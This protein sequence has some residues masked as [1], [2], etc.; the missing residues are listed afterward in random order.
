MT[1]SLDLFVQELL[2]NVLKRQSEE[3]FL[4]YPLECDS[5]IT[6]EMILLMHT[7]DWYDR[8]LEKRLVEYLKRTLVDDGWVQY[9]GGPYDLSASIKAYFALKCAGESFEEPYMRAVAKKIRAHGGL[10]KANVFTRCTLAQFGQLSFKEVPWMP[11]ELILHPK[12][13]PFNVH[14][15]S[16]WARV[17]IVPLT[18]V[19][20]R[21]FKAKN[22]KNISVQELFVDLKVEKPKGKKR[23]F[24]L[25]DE[26]SRFVSACTP[27][28]IHAFA[29]K[30][31]LEWI[32]ERHNNI[33]GLG[34]IYTAMEYEI[35]ALL[36]VGHPIDDPSIQQA[37][38][39]IRFLEH[40]EARYSYMQPCVSPVWDTA[41]AMHALR[42]HQD[43][44]P[45][46]SISKGLDW[47]VSKQL[48]HVPGDWS[49]DRPKLE[50]G[51]WAFQFNNPFYPDLD[52]TAMCGWAMATMDPK[53]YSNSIEKAKNWLLG[54]QSKNGGFAAF[55]ID[56]TFYYLNSIPFAD[57]G[58]LLDPPTEDV[59]GR[60]LSFFGALN[61]PALNPAVKKAV[62]YLK[63]SQQPDGSWWGRWGT[64][65]LYG[66][67]SVITGLMQIGAS[68]HEPWIQR[69]IEFL[70]SRQNP[71]GGWGESCNSYIEGREKEKAPSSLFHTAIVLIALFY[72]KQGEREEVK[73]GVKYLLSRKENPIDE[74]FNAPGFPRVFSLK[75]HGYQTLF[76]LWA[77]GLY[78][79]Q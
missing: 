2:T 43:K 68:S 79:S 14:K 59:T 36:A 6:A 69:G 77:L 28:W 20:T 75:Y 41:I 30:K 19:M 25:L 3:G 49:I 51:G 74:E 73:K 22:P 71:D 26:F 35:K 42:Y 9:P 72:A 27:K 62:N 61:D 7:I 50:G 12:W 48:I 24:Q 4:V 76:P 37:I 67:F 10:R 38:E 33:D 17:V 32:K 39:A 52:D 40:K 13:S 63:A 11:V 23:F 34:G 65:Y 47:L 53:R 8:P 78:Q 66:T 16:Y 1:P 46:D 15:F 55:N 70:F 58:A 44:I 64:N 45:S 56:Q 57:H 21:Q 60:V 31:A 29:E 5:T 18:I 54:M